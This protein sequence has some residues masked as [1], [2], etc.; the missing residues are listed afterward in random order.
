MACLTL[1]GHGDAKGVFVAAL[2]AAGVT[3]DAAAGKVVCD[4]QMFL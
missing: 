3:G 4:V 1:A 2:D